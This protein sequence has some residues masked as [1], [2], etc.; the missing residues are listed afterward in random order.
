MKT[1]TSY[2]LLAITIVGM[3]SISPAFALHDIGHVDT[4]PNATEQKQVPIEVWTDATTYGHTDT[5]VVTGAVANSRGPEVPVTLIVTS[6]T[7]N[8]VTIAQ[9]AVDDGMFTTS[10]STAGD[11]MKYDGVYSIRVQYGPQNVDDFTTVELTGGITASVPTSSVSCEADEVEAGD[12]CYQVVQSISGGTLTGTSVNANTATLSVM[13][14]STDDGTITFS[15]SN[16][17]ISE[18]FMVIVDGEQW[19]DATI[20]GNMVTV[21][22]PA[23][24]ETIELVGTS[25]IPEFGTIAAMILAVAIVSI[26]IVSSKTRLSIIPRY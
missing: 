23:G 2:V 3:F 18:I 22:F 1:S 4:I 16:N 10:I 9:L 15:P 25:A 5:I 19:E 24:T 11:L 14:D 13:I 8:I 12:V 6:P 26:I 7:N 21:M 17:V 20:D